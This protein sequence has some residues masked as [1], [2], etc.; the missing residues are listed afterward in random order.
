[1]TT[2]GRTSAS[3]TSSAWQVA[4]SR[5]PNPAGFSPHSTAQR[6]GLQR[7]RRTGRPTAE[8]TTIASDTAVLP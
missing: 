4:M 1:M 7:W 5:A 6:T 2:A 3:G 8:S